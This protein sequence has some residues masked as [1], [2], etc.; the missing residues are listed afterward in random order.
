VNILEKWVAE[1][2][3]GREVYSCRMKALALRRTLLSLNN[4]FI[5]SKAIVRQNIKIK[6]LKAVLKIIEKIPN[7]KKMN[8]V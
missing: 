3:A 7:V 1:Y 2:E 4:V 5:R 8:L 6:N